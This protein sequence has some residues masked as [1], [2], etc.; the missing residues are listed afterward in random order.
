LLNYLQ[1]PSHPFLISCISRHREN[2]PTTSYGRWQSAVLLPQ[3]AAT[4]AASARFAFGVREGSLVSAARAPFA[5]RFRR[6]VEKRSQR[7]GERIRYF[8]ERSHRW[9][10][11]A[12]L[13][14]GQIAALDRRP[15]GQPL[16]RPV[17]RSTQHLDALREEVQNM[18]FG[19]GQPFNLSETALGMLYDLSDN[20]DTVRDAE[21]HSRS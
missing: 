15:L 11:M 16:L 5:A 17:L 8:Y 21:F 14:V 18:G 2:G 12:A 10:A 4:Y 19:N 13:Q 20:P 1:Q 9:V 3:A 7:H 6:F